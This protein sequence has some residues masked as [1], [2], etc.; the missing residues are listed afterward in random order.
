MEATI[1]TDRRFAII[2][3]WILDANISDKA[4]RLYGILAR[5]ADYKTHKAYPARQTLA[6]RLRCSTRSI[7]RAVLE[8]IEIGALS[9]RQRKDSSLMFVL[10]AVSPRVDKD[11]NIGLTPVSRG[12]DTSVNL[13][14][15]TEQEL[16]NTRFDEFWTVYPKKADKG[17]ARRSF[18]AALKKVPFET[19]LEAAKAYRDDPLRKPDFTKNPSTWLN[20]EAW[21]NAPREKPRGTVTPGMRDWVEVEHGAGEHWACRG[22]EFGH[23]DDWE[24]QPQ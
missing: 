15:T 12:V 5:Y 6:D 2:D 9:K 1:T 22:G 23:P 24:Y 21:E 7:D 10:H 17:L 11:V 16:L 19:V 4:V 3:E 8:L 20:A 18:K 13:T 14:I